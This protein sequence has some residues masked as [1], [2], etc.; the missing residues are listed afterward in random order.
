MASRTVNLW[1]YLP[2]FL[3]Q[4]RELEMLLDSEQIEFQ[5][6]V[7]NT[8]KVLAEPFILTADADGIK[9][10]ETMMNLFPDEDDDLETRRMRVLSLWH[11]NI[12]YTF[13]NLLN[14]IISIQGNRNVEMYYDPDNR[15][16][17]HIETNMEKP[18]M[19][20]TLEKSI[21]KMIPVNIQVISEN[22][23][24]GTETEGNAFI[25]AG[26][27][28]SGNIFL[29]D[30]L[31]GVISS[32]LEGKEAIGMSRSDEFFITDDFRQNLDSDLIGNAA[33]GFGISGQI[34]LTD[35]LKANIDSN[36]D[37]K[38]SVG[39]TVTETITLI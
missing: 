32:R 25:S 18:G 2:P 35:D 10:F 11:N 16:I 21:V 30:D 7:E 3:K 19:V 1:E 9:I 22:H 29:T 15:Y 28:I 14:T 37:L 31:I 5:T 27:S 8:D 38:G 24:E 6:L 12:P 33:V 36:T 13:F 34:F 26:A 4:F 23:F 39:N 20:E 17:L